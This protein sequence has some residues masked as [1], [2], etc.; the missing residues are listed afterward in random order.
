VT[1]NNKRIFFAEYYGNGQLKAKLPLDT[2]GQCNG[3]AAWF[4][5]NGNTES[6]GEYVHGF[7]KGEWT[8]Y[9]QQ[10]KL[11]GKNQYD[12]NGNVLGAIRPN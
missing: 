9:N 5:E 10:G 7:K 6:E 8:N 11:T 1:K 3:P 4:Y 2:F 12:S